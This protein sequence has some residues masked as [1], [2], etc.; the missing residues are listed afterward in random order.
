MLFISITN[1]GVDI[2]SKPCKSY[3]MAFSLRMNS[4]LRVMK[5][6]VA[7]AMTDA[8]MPCDTAPATVWVS[9]LL[10]I[11]LTQQPAGLAHGSVNCSAQNTRNV[12]G[13]L[14][15]DCKPMSFCEAQSAS[16]AA[17]SS[18]TETVCGRSFTYRV[19]LRNIAVSLRNME[20]T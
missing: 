7:L 15:N 12:E 9:Q 18:S 5:L 3:S 11:P 10:G 4:L 17:S 13:S 14:E 8:P 19:P 2:K 16:I 6:L 20:P 1:V